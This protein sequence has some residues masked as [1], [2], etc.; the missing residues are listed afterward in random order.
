[1]SIPG[2]LR[3]DGP[4]QPATNAES[5][6]AERGQGRSPEGRRGLATRVRLQPRRES[7]GHAWSPARA[8]STLRPHHG[9]PTRRQVPPGGRRCVAPPPRAR[10]RAGGP[11]PPRRAASI[12]P[13]TTNAVRPLPNAVADDR[14]TSCRTPQNRRP[15]IGSV[16]SAVGSRPLLLPPVSALRAFIRS[17]REL[18][19]TAALG[20]A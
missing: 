18:C 7:T 6:G 9:S 2:A 17:S 3:V 15:L 11:C 14:S 5:P 16:N 10:A 13:R 8:R 19:G 4:S 20:G 12:D 1:M